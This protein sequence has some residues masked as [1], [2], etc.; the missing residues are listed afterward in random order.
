M[1]LVCFVCFNPKNLLLCKDKQQP[2]PWGGGG[3]HT[4]PEVFIFL[5]KNLLDLQGPTQAMQIETSFSKPGSRFSLYYP[6]PSLE[7]GM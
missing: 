2:S 1:L 7:K 4:D 3:A 6:H 5:L